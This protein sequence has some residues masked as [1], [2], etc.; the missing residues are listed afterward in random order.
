MP[1]SVLAATATP[2]F[3]GHQLPPLGP[4]ETEVQDIWGRADRDFEAAAIATYQWIDERA[5]E[6]GGLDADVLQALKAEANQALAHADNAA[7]S[8]E[9][10]TCEVRKLMEAYGI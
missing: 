4:G 7:Y 9:G 6:A 10:A 8:P 1:G 5:K 2:R 3:L